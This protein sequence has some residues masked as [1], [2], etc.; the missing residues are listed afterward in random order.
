MTAI[1]YLNQYREAVKKAT[2]YKIQYKHELSNIDSLKSS[3]NLDRIKPTGITRITEDKAVRL[4][5][6]WELWAKAEL[7]AIEIRQ[8]IFELIC[9]IPGTE[10]DI[11]IE[12]YLNLKKWEDVCITVN[13]SWYTVHSMHKKALQIVDELLENNKTE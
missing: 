9:E 10:G 1:E 5:Y 6:C 13:A 4:G 8:N 11:L 7:D 3:L 12:R 2:Y